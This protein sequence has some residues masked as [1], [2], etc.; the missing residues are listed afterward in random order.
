MMLTIKVVRAGLQEFAEKGNSALSAL[1]V[2]VKIMGPEDPNWARVR[3]MNGVRRLR[4]GP[5]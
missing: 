4:I 2:D 5:G 3:I 1:E